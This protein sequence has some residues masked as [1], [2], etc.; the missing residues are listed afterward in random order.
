MLL[1]PLLLA[2]GT[3][4]LVLAVPMAK[5]YGTRAFSDPIA[6][7]NGTRA[8][9]Y[10]GV[11]QA[12]AEFGAKKLPGLLNKDYTWPNASSIDVTQDKVGCGEL[13]TDTVL[14]IGWSWHEHLPYPVPDG[15]VESLLDD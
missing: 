15:A 7:R 3:A 4:T 13:S 8:F 9:Q 2:A 6:K 5:P 14:D 12:C 1:L 10:F 11:N